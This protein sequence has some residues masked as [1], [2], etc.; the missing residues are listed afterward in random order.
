MWKSK[1][2]M[3]HPLLTK[4]MLLVNFFSPKLMK[5]RWSSLFFGSFAHYFWIKLSTHGS[6]IYKYEWAK[7]L[8]VDEGLDSK[9]QHS[10]P[11]KTLLQKKL[12]TSHLDCS[13]HIEYEIMHNPKKE[14]ENPY[15]YKYEWVRILFVDEDLDSKLQHC[16]TCKISWK[17]KKKP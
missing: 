3:A 6:N 5:I 10:G 8:F 16:G 1:M 17:K 9:L 12:K 7:I 2:D 4:A 13:S 14:K 11:C 15:I